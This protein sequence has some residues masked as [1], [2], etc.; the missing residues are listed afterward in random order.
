MRKTLLLA[1][2]LGI[3][4]VSSAAATDS[5]ENVYPLAAAAFAGGHAEEAYKM[6]APY[7]PANRGTFQFDLLFGESACHTASA[8]MWGAQ[9]LLEM[10]RR[11]E[12]ELK[13]NEDEHKELMKADIAC[14]GSLRPNDHAIFASHGDS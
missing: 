14:V 11:Y 10:S 7:Y 1:I 6:L 13:N 2:A 5:I 3:G 4:G 12:S 9:Y 8:D